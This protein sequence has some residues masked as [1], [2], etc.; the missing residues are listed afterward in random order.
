MTNTSTTIKFYKHIS[1]LFL[2]I[3][4]VKIEEA[5]WHNNEFESNSE[6]DMEISSVS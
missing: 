2:S 4:S 3:V 6:A 5:T 1:H